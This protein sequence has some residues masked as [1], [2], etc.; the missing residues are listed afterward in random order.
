MTAGPPSSKQ[1]PYLEPRLGFGRAVAALLLLALCALAG[2]LFAAG[3]VAYRE[4]E[5]CTQQ[6]CLGSAAT[7]AYWAGALFC[8]LTG[9]LAAGRV[10]RSPGAGAPNRLPP[11]GVLFLALLLGPLGA[12]FGPGGPYRPAL[13]ALVILAALTLPLVVHSESRLRAQHR[14]YRAARTVAD[15][16]AAHGVSTAGT[17]TAVQ[18]GEPSGYA[19]PQFRLTVGYTTPDGVQRSLVCAIRIQAYLA[20]RV[21]QLMTVRYDPLAPDTAEAAI[22][23]PPEG[24]RPRA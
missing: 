11:G 23:P 20:P 2:R 21:G 13:P 18:P 17:V 8:W 12:A 15:R 4:P 16:L 6:L 24:V 3:V 1:L 19:Q 9:M 5:T 14:A 22:V 10:G 7:Q